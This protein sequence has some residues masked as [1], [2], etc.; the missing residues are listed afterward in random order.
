MAVFNKFQDFTKQLARGKHAFDSHTF[1]VMLTNELPLNT[2]TVA[3]NIKEIASGNGYVAG[4]KV[5]SVT[6]S[7]L[8]DGVSIN[9]TEIVFAASGGSIGPFRYAVLYN[10]STV[11]GPLIGW[12]DYISSVILSDTET[13]TVKFNSASQGSIFTLACLG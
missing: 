3:S 1:K 10:E 13:L 9:G 12:W 5:T 11:G 6:L 7:D 8:A 4:G 2:Y